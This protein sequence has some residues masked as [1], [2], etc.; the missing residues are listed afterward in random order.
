MQNISFRN[1]IKSLALFSVLIACDSNDEIPEF[2]K[3]YESPDFYNYEKESNINN[4]GDF[5]ITISEGKI[6]F[7]T[8]HG[9]LDSPLRYRNDLEEFNFN[10]L[11]KI[12]SENGEKYYFRF[13]W[14]E[15]ENDRTIFSNV[16]WLKNVPPLNEETY[17][18]TTVEIDFIQEGFTSVCNIGDS[19]TWW[20]TSQYFRKSMNYYFEDLIFV[21]SNTDIYGYGHEG[22]GGNKTSD[23]LERI[24]LIP[25]ADY[26]TVLLGTN[27]YKRNNDLAFRNIITLFEKL[28]DS[29]PDSKII[30]ISPLPSDKESRNEFNSIL[31]A[32][33]LQEIMDKSNIIYVNI[34]RDM[35]YNSNWLD[36]YL[37]SDGLHLSSDGVDL[38]AQKIAA[39]IEAD[40][41]LSE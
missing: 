26:Y 41:K 28:T 11:Y 19:Q 1:F 36:E 9:N 10:G 17:N 16:R 35:K 32:K 2:T 27:D 8:N 22:E 38:M 31:E 4:L 20:K 13:G 30:Y 33:I 21:G 37:I 14:M 34:A 29:F 39:T 7:N 6:I 3:E 24:D 18:F 5:K 23:V 25:E 15:Y 40:I 12:T